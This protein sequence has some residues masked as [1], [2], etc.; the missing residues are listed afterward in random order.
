MSLFAICEVN[1]DVD[2]E[3]KEIEPDTME[4]STQGPRIFV[5]T[6][7]IKFRRAYIDLALRIPLA[8]FAKRVN[9]ENAYASVPGALVLSVDVH[10]KLT[11]TSLKHALENAA[12]LAE[13]LTKALRAQVEHFPDT[14]KT[15]LTE[16]EYVEHF[17]RFTEYAQEPGYKRPAFRS[18]TMSVSEDVDPELEV[19]FKDALWLIRT[20]AK[21]IEDD[22]GIDAFH[23]GKGTYM[24][25]M[26]TIHKKKMTYFTYKPPRLDEVDRFSM[27][28]YI[29]AM[30]RMQPRRKKRKSRAK[31]PQLGAKPQVRR[32]AEEDEDE[33]ID[34]LEDIEE[35][36]EEEEEEDEIE[37][38]D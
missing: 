17:K 31:L 11:P 30:T 2:A 21:T 4:V 16:E 10:E 28:L 7:L 20:V 15:T 22:K 27:M 13:S 25:E 14:E 29:A 26:Y 1:A 5:N 34:V 8:N 19:G 18:L 32:V 37:D 24:E 12:R 33:D 3:K 9:N 6:G 23:V 35:F 36:E 38:D